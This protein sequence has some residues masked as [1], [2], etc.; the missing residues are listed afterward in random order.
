VLKKKSLDFSRAKDISVITF[1]FIHTLPIAS[2]I[3]K[4]IIQVWRRLN[5]QFVR[6]KEWYWYR[7]RVYQAEII[8]KYVNVN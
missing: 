5:A 3:S 7:G 2:F 1:W 8:M 6:T 4:Y